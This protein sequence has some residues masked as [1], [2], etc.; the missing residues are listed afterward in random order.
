MFRR[1]SSHGTNSSAF[2][3]KLLHHSRKRGTSENGILLGGFAEVFLPKMGPKELNEYA[4]IISES[5]IDLFN[6]LSGAQ[7]VPNQLQSLGT[8]SQLRKYCADIKSKASVHI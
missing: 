2:V 5:D 8:F 1:W 6:W 3:R 7:P 4:M